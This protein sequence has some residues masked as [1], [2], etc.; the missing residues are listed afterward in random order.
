VCVCV[1]SSAKKLLADVQVSEVM[2]FAVNNL[3]VKDSES[4]NLI[5]NTLSEAYQPGLTYQRQWSFRHPEWPVARGREKSGREGNAGEGR[6]LALP[7]TLDALQM[8]ARHVIIE[9]HVWMK[10]PSTIQ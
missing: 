7:F 2:H 10:D 5:K 3:N 6:D 9:R 4:C 1:S 8:S